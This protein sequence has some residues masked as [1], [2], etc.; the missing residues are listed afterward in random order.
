MSR[1][2]LLSAAPDAAPRAEE[3]RSRDC[4]GGP[5]AHALTGLQTAERRHMS[6][7][8][9]KRKLRNFPVANLS[10]RIASAT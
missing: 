6:A 2:S 7:D 9:L 1:I 5:V 8:D 4:T 10:Q 3:I